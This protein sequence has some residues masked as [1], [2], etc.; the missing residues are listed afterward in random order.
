[1][2]AYSAYGFTQTVKETANKNKHAPEGGAQWSHVQRIIGLT[3]I[4]AQARPPLLQSG[5]V[6]RAGELQNASGS[7]VCPL[8]LSLYV[9]VY[10]FS[11][12]TLP[13]YTHPN[14]HI[15]VHDCL[16]SCGLIV[17]L[18][19]IRSTIARFSSLAKKWSC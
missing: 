7:V 16:T 2:T 13:V 9:D 3:M 1:M 10:E 5:L 14:E 8:S 19:I 12:N 17:P 4:Y 11:A 18:W 15:T 6:C